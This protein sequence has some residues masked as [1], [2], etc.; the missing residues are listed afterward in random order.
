M[1]IVKKSSLQTRPGGLRCISKLGD[2]PSGAWPGLVFG[3]GGKRVIILKTERAKW[4]KL[5][6]QK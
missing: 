6:L 2:K 3:W 5:N 4:I 1:R